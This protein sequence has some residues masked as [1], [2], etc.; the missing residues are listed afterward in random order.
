MILGSKV[1]NGDDFDGEVLFYESEDGMTFTYKNRFI[2][3][4]IGNM[5]ECPDLFELDGQ[6]FLVFSP[7]N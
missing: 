2:D 3:S 6:Y 4:S 7:E 5:W 1:P